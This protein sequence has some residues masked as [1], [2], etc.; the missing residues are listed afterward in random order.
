MNE[1]VIIPPPG[2]DA[3]IA[4]G[5]KC[6]VMDNARGAGWLCS[7]QYWVNAACPLHGTE[8]KE[9]SEWPRN[10]HQNK[11]APTPKR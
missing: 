6:P 11:P 3:A 8:R 5:C 10:Q 4:A 9:D 2:S 7:G 1:K